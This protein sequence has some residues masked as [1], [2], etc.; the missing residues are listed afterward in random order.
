MKSM[1]IITANVTL[2]K[3]K[4]PTKIYIKEAVSIPAPIVF[5]KNTLANY[6]CAKD[7]AQSLKYDAVFDTAP[8]TYSIVSII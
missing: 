2:M 5:S 4:N 1:H 8:K 7:K 3:M 6:P